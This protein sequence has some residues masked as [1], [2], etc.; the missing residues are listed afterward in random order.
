[1][2]LRFPENYEILKKGSTIWIVNPIETLFLIR[3]I[4]NEPLP[5]WRKQNFDNLS[6]CNPL[7]ERACLRTRKY[8]REQCISKTNIP[9]IN[10]IYRNLEKNNYFSNNG[11]NA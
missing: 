11:Y 2:K 4:S 8:A 10:I 6:K 9:N 1:M 7:I 3:D 5:D